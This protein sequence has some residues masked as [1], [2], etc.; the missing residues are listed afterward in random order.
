MIALSLPTFS[1]SEINQQT[2][3]QLK[4]ALLVNLRRQVLVAVCDDLQLRNQ[5]SEQL[6][7]E[8]SESGVLDSQTT[9]ILPEQ[10]GS[11]SVPF[12]HQLLNPTQSTGSHHPYPAKVQLVSLQLN[13]HDP[14]PISPVE[15]WL[16][17]NTVSFMHNSV[18]GFQILGVE[19]LT[20]QSPAVQWSFL[21]Y[22]R[23]LHSH[24]STLEATL[25]LWVPSPWLGCIR[26]SAT[27]FWQSCKGV[28]Q[29]TGD[30][31]PLQARPGSSM[32]Q[33]ASESEASRSEL[34]DLAEQ[35]LKV[36]PSE[37]LQL[38]QLQQEISYRE[39]QFLQQQTLQRQTDAEHSSSVAVELA[40]SYEKL[41]NFYRDRLQSPAAQAEDLELAIQAYEQALEQLEMSD[42]ADS[43]MP[44]SVELLQD[45]GV[46]YW[47]Q[48]RRQVKIQPNPS[49]ITSVLER[50]IIL[51]QTALM[52]SD[53]E[54]P[55]ESYIKLQK[56]LGIA[57]G[58][59]ARI[60]QPVE[61]LQQ[62]VAAYQ[63]AIRGVSCQADLDTTEIAQAIAL[64]NN[65]GT[66]CWNLAQ[67]TR[68][69]AYLQQAIAAYQSAL[70]LAT[71]QQDPSRYAM[72][73]TNLG[74]AYW[75]L[76]Q[77]QPP[78][79]PKSATLLLRA[80]A[81]YCSA[82]QYRTA[83]VDPVACATVQ[84]NLGTT[85][86]HLAQYQFSVHP[87]QAQ[88]KRY[89]EQALA[90]YK[91]A[92]TLGERLNP[93][94]LSFKP[95]STYQNLGMVAYQ[96]GTLT[97]KLVSKAE[98]IAYLQAA[99]DYYLQAGS[100]KSSMVTDQETG[101][102]QPDHSIVSE[103]NR[104]NLGYLGKTIHALYREAG[105]QGQN[106]ALSQIPPGLLPEVLRFL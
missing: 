100:W 54:H 20:R 42:S 28:F 95:Q 66:T 61:N 33:A 82:L 105:I 103:A 67:Q 53:A 52:S 12:P 24:L 92:I 104:T 88:H 99:V 106:Q 91:G 15:H 102:K 8:L 2:Y 51:Y 89:L 62:S 86:W 50:S 26:Q 71:P 13:L 27:E 44:N 80:T 43:E 34:E 9:T 4:Q 11:T 58:D 90:A 57:Y 74:T 70:E 3:L 77:H 14:N 79:S 101:Q 40:R 39:L 16:A 18:L 48:Y 49:S 69:A 7:A 21:R 30:P 19:Q 98:R 29:F 73:Q 22:L 63:E 31:T 78:T 68:S 41:G 85:Y 5:L 36:P 17:K 96:L 25:V 56:N 10:A 81:A 60:R 23:T 37:Q 83:K 59:L 6:Q 76:S 93:A 65:L 45:L 84:N 55:T 97:L 64:Y 47:M 38:E 35:Q 46:L 72:L 94:H 32:I 75:N 1:L 87:E